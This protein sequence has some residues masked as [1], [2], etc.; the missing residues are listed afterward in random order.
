MLRHL[1]NLSRRAR[2]FSTA[3]A[4]SIS[5]TRQAAASVF[6][7]L[8]DVDWVDRE[9]NDQERLIEEAETRIVAYRSEYDP[10]TAVQ[11]EAKETYDEV[12]KLHEMKEAARIV[13]LYGDHI[14]HL[15]RDHE[16]M[17]GFMG[18]SIQVKEGDMDAAEQ[19]LSEYIEFMN[20]LESD[21]VRKKVEHELGRKVIMLKMVMSAENFS[22]K[23]GPIAGGDFITKTK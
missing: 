8:Q 12:K 16:D 7:R 6:E 23:F 10:H 5:P 13:S 2:T 9:T 1:A 17:V 20:L 3:P 4:P 11:G 14:D 22:S 19:T 18:N 15:I 21:D